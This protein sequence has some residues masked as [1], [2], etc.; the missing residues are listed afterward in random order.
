M[1]F[2]SE[3]WRSESA[4]LV[5][6]YGGSETLGVGYVVVGAA[7]GAPQIFAPNCSP[8]QNK[9]LGASGLEIGGAPKTQIQRP[10][11]QQAIL[12]PLNFSNLG[13]HFGYFLFFPLGEGEGG[14]KHQKGGEGGQIL[15]ENPRM[16]GGGVCQERGEGGAKG[17]E[18]VCGELEGGAKFF[19]QGRNS[20]REKYLQARKLHNTTVS[21]KLNCK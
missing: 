15:S 17:Q 4:Q 12:G 8:L 21:K 13:G 11:I 7:F 16:E 20:H 2:F 3:K 19:F 14:S 6:Y 5:K 9:G 1:L 18:G 10:R